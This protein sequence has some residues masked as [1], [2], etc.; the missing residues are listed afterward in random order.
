MKPAHKGWP[1]SIREFIEDGIYLGPGPDAVC[2][3]PGCESEP[4][5]E[6]VYEDLVTAESVATD[7][8]GDASE[9][10]GLPE[11]ELW[12]SQTGDYYC[13]EHARN[14]CLEGELDLPAKLR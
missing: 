11:S 3:W 14:F 9:R 2:G 7:L 1:I 5:W 8:F 13:D 4:K 6:V 10:R 12:S